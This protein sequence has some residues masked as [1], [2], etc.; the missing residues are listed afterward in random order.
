[1]EHNKFVDDFGNEIDV[2]VVS[3]DVFEQWAWQFNA[4]YEAIESEM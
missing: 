2:Y 3:I 1:M 4:A